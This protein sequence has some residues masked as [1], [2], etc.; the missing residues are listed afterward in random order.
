MT[1]ATDIAAAVGA[2]GRT[3]AAGGLTAACVLRRAGKPDRDGVVSFTDVD[4]NGVISEA[5][6]AAQMRY[7]E[8]AQSGLIKVIVMGD[9]AV[10]PH[11]RVRLPKETK[12][13]RVVGVEGM[14]QANGCRFATRLYLTGD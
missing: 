3:L 4:F 13:H 14:R 12:D 9:L 7:S 11:D 10:S 5:S 2:V 8:T 1:L 6:D